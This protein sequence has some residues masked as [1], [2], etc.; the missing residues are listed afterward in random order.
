MNTT[1]AITSLA[2]AAV[3]IAFAS[4]CGSGRANPGA[5]APA[6]CGPS[7]PGQSSCSPA[8][9]QSSTTA[10]AAVPRLVDLG[11]NRCAP[12]KAMAPILEGLRT[13]YAGR[14]EVQ[15]IDVW[16]DPDAA[17]PYRIHMIPTQIF[18]SAD[19]VE[20]SRHEGFMSREAILERWRA[21]GLAL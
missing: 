18:Y 4:G 5:A 2:A 14:L 10:R 17:E 15:F 9:A 21:H 7:S 13:Q 1:R 8:P 19:G 20:L 12:C 11:A 6:D 16:K 3:L